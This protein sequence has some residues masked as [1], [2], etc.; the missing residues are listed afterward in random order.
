MR[1]LGPEPRVLLALALGLG[2]C[3]PRGSAPS[4]APLALLAAESAYADLRAVRD[5][6]EITTA[7]GRRESPE[8]VT[9][10]VLRRRHDALRSALVSRLTGVDSTPLG[11]D[12]R[13]ALAVM[14]GALERDLTPVAIA[15]EALPSAEG[16][17]DCDYRAPAVAA[18]PKGLDSLRGRVYACYGWA[19]HHVILEGDSLD[20][21]SASGALARTEDSAQR[22][23]LFLA[24]EPVWRSVNGDGGLESPYRLLLGLSGAAARGGS[25]PW[26]SERGHSGSS[27]RRWSVGSGPF[28]RPGVGSRPIPCLSRGTGTTP[29][30]RRVGGSAL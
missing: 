15:L 4:P 1:L 12:D 18:A 11:P 24:L 26:K 21:L 17:P 3:A 16:P 23:R 2:A 9:L 30:G 22:R 20:R 28:W 8:G 27:P 13:R 5:R 14:R 25:R 10:S 7:S 6:I 29:L 19:Q